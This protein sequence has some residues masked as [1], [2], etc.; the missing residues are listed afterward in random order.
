MIADPGLAGCHA[1][2][3]FWYPGVLTQMQPGPPP[4]GWMPVHSTGICQDI[5][6][7]GLM[8]KWFRE[9]SKEQKHAALIRNNPTAEIIF[10][11]ARL[12]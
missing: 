4:S 7:E 8:V 12:S 3:F 6:L 10:Q 2:S 5:M 9:L 11:K 1:E